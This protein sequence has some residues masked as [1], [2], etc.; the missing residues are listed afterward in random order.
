[1]QTIDT[2]ATHHRTSELAEENA[3]WRVTESAL[4]ATILRRDTQLLEMQHR[5]A[6][7]LQIIASILQTKA[8]A[9]ECER[10][11]GHLH[12]ACQRVMAVAAVQEQLKSSRYGDAVAIG[13]YLRRLCETLAGSMIGGDRNI[14]VRVSSAEDDLPTSDVMDL[15]LIVTELLINAVKYAFPDPAS[16][17]EIAVDY[18][19]GPAG[20]SLEV[21]DNGAGLAAGVDGGG[22]GGLG[23]KLLAAL[24]RGLSARI[25]TVSSPSGTRVTIRSRAFAHSSERRLEP[26]ELT[27]YSGN[28]RL[29]LARI[30]C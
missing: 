17:G 2:A 27:Q 28:I 3:A 13:P 25:E 9:V 20:W 7:S 30:E 18:R 22:S 16:C 8:R 5:M 15:G 10:T 14:A 23:S 29:A 21:S 4:K 6:N 12:E 11:R 24:A 1:M 19:T 26:A